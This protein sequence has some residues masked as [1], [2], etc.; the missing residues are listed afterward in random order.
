LYSLKWIRN[1]PYGLH[2]RHGAPKDFKLHTFRHTVA[3]WLKNK[4]LSTWERGLVLNHSVSGVTE[5]YSHGYP[6]QAKRELLTKWA[7][8]LEGLVTA[9]GVSR[10]R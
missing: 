8:H 4:G 9:E 10:L 2:F 6:V 7:N 1:G 3:T 5:E